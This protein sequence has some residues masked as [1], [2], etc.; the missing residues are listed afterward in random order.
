MRAAAAGSDAM[1]MAPDPL[2]ARIGRPGTMDLATSRSLITQAPGLA[3][4]CY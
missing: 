3:V 4:G 1:I 2:R